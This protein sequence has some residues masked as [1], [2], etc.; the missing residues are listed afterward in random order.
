MNVRFLRVLGANAQVLKPGIVAVVDD[1]L[2]RWNGGDWT[3]YCPC[4]EGEACP[5]LDAVLALLD[6]R[7]LGEAR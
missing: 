3:T 7:V 4:P 2:V 5:H 6:D 1:H